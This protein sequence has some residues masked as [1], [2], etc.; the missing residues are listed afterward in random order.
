MDPFNGFSDQTE[1]TCVRVMVTVV[2][3][4]QRFQH[5]NWARALQSFQKVRE[6]QTLCKKVKLSAET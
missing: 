1:Q 3:H 5:T 2:I 6:V 4:I